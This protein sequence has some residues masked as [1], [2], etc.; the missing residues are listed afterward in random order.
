MR[1]FASWLRHCQNC[2]RRG[3]R[4][5]ICATPARLSGGHLISTK[6]EDLNCDGIDDD[7]IT[8]KETITSIVM[9]G[10]QVMPTIPG[11]PP[12]SKSVSNINKYLEFCFTCVKHYLF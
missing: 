11:L 10:K 8:N 6:E 5:A 4:S 3:L 1:E 7:P 12:I 9:E 2:D